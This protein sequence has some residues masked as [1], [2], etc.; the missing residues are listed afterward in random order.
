MISEDSPIRWLRQAR[1]FLDENFS[2]PLTLTGIAES[3]KVHPVYL[4]NAFRLHYHSS[5]GEYLRHRRVEFACHKISTSTDSLA[6]IALA[7]GFSNQSHFTRIF[8]QV[9]GMTPVQ[10]RAAN[11][12]S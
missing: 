5:V 7:A 2:Q 4:A 6:E 12:P 10:Y 11:K 9:T 3:V 1:E 8:K